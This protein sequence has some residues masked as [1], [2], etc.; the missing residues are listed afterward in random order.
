MSKR[1]QTKKFTRVFYQSSKKCR[2][3][4]KKYIKNQRFSKKKE[5]FK[6]SKIIF[7]FDLVYSQ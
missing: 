1:V 6:N 2:N 7:Q 4:I 5:E 3:N